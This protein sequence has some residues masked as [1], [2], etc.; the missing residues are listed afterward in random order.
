MRNK[1]TPSVNGISNE[2]AYRRAQRLDP[3]PVHRVDYQP[4]T[5]ELP[6]SIPLPKFLRSVPPSADVK[7]EAAA[8]SRF[9][10]DSVRRAES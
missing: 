7:G 2:V 1:L 8:T 3:I 5:F 6:E 4:R 10:G 9:A